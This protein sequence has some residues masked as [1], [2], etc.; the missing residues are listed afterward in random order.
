[1]EHHRNHIRDGAVP[2][3][4]RGTLKL[5]EIYRQC[6][7]FV[8]FLLPS[9]LSIFLRRQSL[10]N[11]TM[12]SV[13]FGLRKVLVHQTTAD[14]DKSRIAR[15]DQLWG[16]MVHQMGQQHGMGPPAPNAF[17]RDR[18]SNG[19]F[20]V[21]EPNERR[22]WGQLPSSACLPGAGQCRSDERALLPLF[23]QL[24]IAS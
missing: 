15:A 14:E 21:I 4:S 23:Y 1:M 7:F 19:G 11:A 10:C 3:D 2:T 9:K 22:L 24:K 17:L 18:A 12:L 20:R 5:F 16:Q 8:V 13:I 6:T